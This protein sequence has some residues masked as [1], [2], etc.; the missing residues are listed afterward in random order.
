MPLKHSR[1]ANY[2][3]VYQNAKMAESDQNSVWW[4][5]Y[6]LI[7]VGG[8]RLNYWLIMVPASNGEKNREKLLGLPEIR[9]KRG[10]F[11]EYRK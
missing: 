7:P 5:Q 10:V 4:T 3:L 6:L 2:N 1:E 9:L 11:M 8:A